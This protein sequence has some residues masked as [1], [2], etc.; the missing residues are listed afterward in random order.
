[1]QRLP[2]R[3]FCRLFEAGARPGGVL[4]PY[5]FGMSERGLSL[6]GV[7]FMTGFGGFD[8]FAGSGKHL[9]LVCL[10][11]KIQHN[12]ATVAVLTVLAVSTVMAVSVMMATPLNLNPPFP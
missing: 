9:T 8:S 5:F 11:Y 6:R 1:M 2:Y 3:T 10:S 4:S 7:A 12:E